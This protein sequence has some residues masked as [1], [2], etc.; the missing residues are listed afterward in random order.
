VVPISDQKLL[1]LGDLAMERIEVVPAGS[2]DSAAYG[3]GIPELAASCYGCNCSRSA[4]LPEDWD[5][6]EV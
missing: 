2:L 6:A 4:Y 5:W 1:D 3:H